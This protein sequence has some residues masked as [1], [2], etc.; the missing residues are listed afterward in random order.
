MDTA[1]ATNNGFHIDGTFISR[2]VAEHEGIYFFHTSLQILNTGTQIH[3]MTL[4]IRK[5]GTDLEYTSS[6][7]SIHGRHAGVDGTQVLSTAYTISL[8]ANDYVELLW[9]S[10]AS[11]VTLSNI[12]AGTTP[13]TPTTPSVS[14]EVVQIMYTQLGPQGPQGPSVGPD[15]VLAGNVTADYVSAS[16]GNVTASSAV[17]RG[18]FGNGYNISHIAAGNITTGQLANARLPTNVNIGGTFNANGYATFA[19]NVGV[20][21]NL[22]V[23]DVNSSGNVTV[24]NGGFLFGNGY[25]LGALNAA[26]VTTGQLVNARLPTNVNIGGTLNANGATTLVDATL[27]GNLQMQNLKQLRLYSTTQYLDSVNGNA[28]RVY[29][30]GPSN[31][32]VITFA[33]NATTVGSF[34]FDGLTVTGNAGVSK[35]VT[36]AA[37]SGPSLTAAAAT[38]LVLGAGGSEKARID[39]NGN[40]GIGNASAVHSLSV[41]GT[42]YVRNALTMQGGTVSAPS[43]INFVA[44]D[45]GVMIE[46]RYAANDRYGI[47]QYTGGVT[48]VYAAGGYALA[49]LKLCFATAENT[50]TDAL[51]C[52]TTGNVGIGTS[53]PA[54]QLQLST[55]SAAKPTTSTWT[56]SSDRR[57]K[58]NIEDADLDICYDTVK[59]LPLRRFTYDANVFPSVPDRSV[60]GWVAQEV[61]NVLPKA[62]SITN[63]HG[64]P[65]F[66]GL[67]VDQIY[68]T[69]YGAL[70]KVI[71]RN[72]A[73]EARVALLEVMRQP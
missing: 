7:S 54:Y 46:K 50:F 68:K 17:G 23:H 31:G 35:T 22:G 61:V 1:G 34:G 72:E 70:R 73:L 36:A 56:I 48:R 28:L 59:T 15:L 2:I 3:K 71:D 10:D 63:Q 29:S 16:N 43:G 19:G 44:T 52:V 20:T 57:V 24:N 64:F 26:N 25:Y 27:T 55:D 69:M 33:S 38:S 4:W 41:N 21:G 14:V 66:L 11:D 60:V 62:V 39:A 5:N 53:S 45:P 12:P 6:R 47:G 37:F 65:D 18:F 8:N 58:L 9:Q 67:D 13:T 49:T 30:Y 32:G 40:V 42:T 51:T